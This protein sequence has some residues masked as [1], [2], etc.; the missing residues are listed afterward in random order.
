[1]AI[2]VGHTELCDIVINGPT[3][4]P[5][6]PGDYILVARVC[7]CGGELIDTDLLIMGPQVPHWT[8]DDVRAIVAKSAGGTA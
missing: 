3:N 5:T 7:T 6:A 2:L 8:A 4:L 1:M